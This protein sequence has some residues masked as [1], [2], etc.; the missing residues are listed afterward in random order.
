MQQVYLNEYNKSWT[1]K[2]LEKL[3]EFYDTT[4]NMYGINTYVLR[5]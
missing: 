5:D 3:K 4:N 1:D 2:D